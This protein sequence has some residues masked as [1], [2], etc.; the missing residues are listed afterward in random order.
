MVRAASLL[1]PGDALDIAC[2]GGRHAIWLAERGWRVVAVD[3]DAEAAAGIGAA[4]GGVEVRVADLESGEF[5]IEANSYD[6]AVCWLYFQRD[7]L[8]MIREGVR[9][10]GI[11][12][13]CVLLEGRFAAQ[14]GELQACFAG[15][16]VVHEAETNHGP[17]K[18]ACELVVQRP[19]AMK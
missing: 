9:P 8:P 1:T 3:R 18:R 14:P 17:G 19:R 15:W 13:L 12:A 4:A 5:T 6:L 2:G 11:A 16:T 10:G 7:L